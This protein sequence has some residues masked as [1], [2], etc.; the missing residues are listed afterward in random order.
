MDKDRCFCKLKIF[1]D[2]FF[3]I[4]DLLITFYFSVTLVTNR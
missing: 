4:D 3:V 2:K 1:L